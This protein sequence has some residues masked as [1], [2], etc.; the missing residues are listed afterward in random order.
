MDFFETEQLSAKNSKTLP[1]ITWNGFSNEFFSRVTYCFNM[2][3]IGCA[4]SFFSNANILFFQRTKTWLSHNPC[5]VLWP[6]GVRLY[7]LIINQSYH[8]AQ[9]TWPVPFVV[10]CVEW[11]STILCFR[12][13]VWIIR[14]IVLGEEI[15]QCVDHFSLSV[16]TR[17][18]VPRE[19]KGLKK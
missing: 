19:R 8:S 13:K 12:L 11:S 6:R 3:N 14:R 9:Y 2:T 17:M 15:Q 16:L 10:L 4:V 1:Q 5:F 7:F 18:R